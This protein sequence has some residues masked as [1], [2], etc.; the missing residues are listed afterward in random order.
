V[1]VYKDYYEVLG[2]SRTSDQDGIKSAFRK[3]AAKHHPDRNL[4][5]AGAEERFKEINEAYTVLSD[6]E[7]RKFYNQFG[8]AE[9]HPT[10]PSQGGPSYVNAEDSADFSDFFQGLFGGTF[11]GGG[12]PFAEFRG[13][14]PTRQNV[15][16]SLTID[17][18]SAY[19]GDQTTITVDGRRLDVRIP[20]G[21]RAGTKLRLRG[22]APGGGDLLLKLSLKRHPTFAL[23]GD[24]VRVKV[25]VPDFTAVLGG[26]VRVPTL[27]GA[28]EMTLPK[29]TQT[30]RVLRLRGKGWPKRTGGQGDEL[31]E[32]R[33]I[34][35]E[36]PSDEQVELYERLA[37]AQKQ[38]ARAAA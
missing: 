20:Q 13:G 12:D 38:T 28:V 24:D 31:A 10:F 6:P 1:A 23:D 5:D 34:V 37:G 8:T 25:P 17:L 11:R 15:Q 29:G 7:K 14:A 36:S 30:G 3:L 19:R 4:N 27:D 32:V 9:G 35:P 2:V 22:H 18:V 21:A 26:N 33:V 16:A